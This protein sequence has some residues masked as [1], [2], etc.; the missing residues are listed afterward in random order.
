MAPTAA[1]GPRSTRR[2]NLPPAGDN[3]LSNSNCLERLREFQL[4]M[5]RGWGGPFALCI[6][7]D[8]IV[9]NAVQ[10]TS[11]TGGGSL[12]KDDDKD[13]VD[14]GNDY[15]S[16]DN[17]LDDDDDDVDNAVQLTS[18]PSGGS[19]KHNFPNPRDANDPPQQSTLGDNHIGGLPFI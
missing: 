2:K 8:D 1:P 4:K 5:H 19:H 16:D 15:S 17:N 3:E 13:N 14:D 6:N 18:S 11:N 10:L 12:E 7:N 9:D